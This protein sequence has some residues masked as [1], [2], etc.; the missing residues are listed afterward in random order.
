MNEND[1]KNWLISILYNICNY[2]N[3]IGRKKVLMFCLS[4]GG[5]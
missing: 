4:F 3:V 5:Y 1:K 2:L